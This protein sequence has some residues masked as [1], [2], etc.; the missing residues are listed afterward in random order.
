MDAAE[1]FLFEDCTFDYVFSEHMLEHIP[2]KQV[3][4]LYSPDKSRLQ[5]HRPEWDIDYQHILRYYPDA[6]KIAPAS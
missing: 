3:L 6:N 2:Y 5:K 1:R 4:G